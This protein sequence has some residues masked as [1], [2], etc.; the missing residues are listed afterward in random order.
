MGSSF[1][2]GYN[3]VLTNPS[4]DAF[5]KFLNA[6]LIKHYDKHYSKNVLEVYFF[7]TFHSPLQKRSEGEG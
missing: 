4:Q 3:I 7:I 1:H 2:F 5:I 6:S